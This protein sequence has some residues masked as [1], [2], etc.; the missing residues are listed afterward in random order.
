MTSS[1]VIRQACRSPIVATVITH[2]INQQ[3]LVRV[4]SKEIRLKMRA[5]CCAATA[6]SSRYL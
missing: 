4:P 6:H 2:M 5:I 1:Y 3:R